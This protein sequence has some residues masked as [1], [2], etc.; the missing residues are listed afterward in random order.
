M[1]TQVHDLH[2]ARVKC[3]YGGF[4]TIYDRLFGTLLA[5]KLDVV[6][7][8][9]EAQMRAACSKPERSTE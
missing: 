2:H 4:T 1:T 8:R 6:I 3:C 5:G 9:V 7:C